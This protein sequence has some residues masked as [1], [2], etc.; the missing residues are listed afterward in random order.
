MK[1]SRKFHIDWSNNLAACLGLA[2]V[3]CVPA[4]CGDGQETATTHNDAQDAAVFTADGAAIADSNA[5]TPIL[6]ADAGSG[7]D[8]SDAISSSGIPTTTKVAK[9]TS[10]D[11]T[12]IC[13]WN[14]SLFGGYGKSKRC[15][16]ELSW[17]GPDDRATCVEELESI[18]KSCQGTVGEYEICQRFFV[19]SAAC[20]EDAEFPRECA[21]FLSC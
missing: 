3:A 2:I 15:S 18:S 7:V 11:K 5:M 12:R 21:V 9:L 16:N 20:K 1:P 6:R 10:A 19:T 8:G 13:D 4:G 17:T 14:A